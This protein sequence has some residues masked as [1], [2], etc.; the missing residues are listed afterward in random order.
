VF[1]T[2]TIRGVA[3]RIADA[4]RP[5]TD[6]RPALPDGLVVLREGGA[7][8]PLFCAPPASGSPLC[9][10]GL[11][12][13]LGD[14]RPIY[15]FQMPGLNDDAA[16]LR[17]V[18]DMAAA[19]IQTMRAVQPEG[20]Y[21]I[22]GW[23]LGGLIALEMERQLARQGQHAARLVLIDPDLQRSSR[24]R[25]TARLAVF[26]PALLAFAGRAGMFSSYQGFQQ[27]ARWIGLSL[28]ASLD[29]LP[30][31]GL[32]ARARLLAAL[33]ADG[34]RSWRVFLANIEALRSYTPAPSGAPL[35]LFHTAAS[36]Q[37]LQAA[38]RLAPRGLDV[39]QAPGTHM[40]LMLDAQIVQQLAVQLRA[41]LRA[42]HEP[43]A[44]LTDHPPELE[45]EISTDP[46]VCQ[47]GIQ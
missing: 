32:R 9:Y 17:R 7:G 21:L 16:P 42:P 36:S 38:Q 34:L 24:L 26:F 14:D 31:R 13:H 1:Q 29:D 18:E 30:Q 3:A 25:D 40:T 20:P 22:C 45:R 35:L 8:A 33:G 5:R 6:S 19:F 39:Q 27:V 37:A 47:G 2:P 4:L 23:S 44:I 12:Q 41:A 11:A 28:P 10:V 46:M 15:G 43:H